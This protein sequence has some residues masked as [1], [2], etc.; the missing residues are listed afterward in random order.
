MADAT[1]WVTL[2]DSSRQ[3]NGIASRYH[4][5]VFIVSGK[6]PICGA[7]CPA[8]REQ[9]FTAVSCRNN[10]LDCEN[11]AFR[12]LRTTGAVVEIGDVGMFMN[13]TTHTMAA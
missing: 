7:Y 13:R 11:Q 5:C 6:A 3:Q 10:G 8:V 9:R 12:E 2:E 4:D 1:R